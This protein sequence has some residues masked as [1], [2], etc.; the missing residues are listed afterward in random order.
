MAQEGFLEEE[1]SWQREK[2][3]RRR[4][5]KD[6][7]DTHEREKGSKAGWIHP[8]LPTQGQVGWETLGWERVGWEAAEAGRGWGS[9]YSAWDWLPQASP[10]LRGTDND[11]IPQHPELLFPDWDTEAQ[12]SS[13]G[14]QRPVGR[15]GSVNGHRS[16]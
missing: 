8:K 16:S 14:G 9:P 1:N 4:P 12:S 2:G 10:S 3:E 5:D 11:P 15:R 13:A 6:Q 7:G